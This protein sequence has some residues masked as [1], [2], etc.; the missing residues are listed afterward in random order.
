MPALPPLRLT[1][2]RLWLG[3]A[4]LLLW[5]VVFAG[6]LLGAAERWAYD[7][8]LTGAA[9][10]GSPEVVV[11]AIDAP[12]QARHGSWPW[13][14]EL[15]GRLVDRLRGAGARVVAHA[16]PFIGAQ[17]PSALAEWHRIASTVAA[18]PA[19][20]HHPDLPTVLSVSREQL[21][22]DGQ[23]A[24]SLAA[25]GRSLLALG[26]L[27]AAS[28][29]TGE[30]MAALV[31]AEPTAAGTNAA[32]PA[33]PPWPLPL[34]ARAALGSGHLELDADRDGT[35]RRHALRRDVEGRGIASLA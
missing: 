33:R 1:K 8:A 17:S 12:S 15:H 11:V 9:R 16:E 34:L 5:L 4:G 6:D 18:D 23:F 26:P 27:E 7:H 3:G 22:G 29:R 2:E 31:D 32:V 24:H 20:A 30:A 35:L 13:S 14:R 10:A 19:L 25:H 21:D 28:L